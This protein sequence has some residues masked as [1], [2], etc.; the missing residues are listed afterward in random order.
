[1]PNG[2]PDFHEVAEPDYERFFVPIATPLHD[3][4][5]RHNVKLEKYYHEAPVW[6]FLFRHPLGGVA[7]NDVEKE[8]QAH[9]TLWKYW[10][11]DDYDSG[12]RSI[13]QSRSE[14]FPCEPKDLAIRLDNALNEILSW[15]AQSW[16]GRHGGFSDI[17]QGAW[18]REAFK[19]MELAYPVVTP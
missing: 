12:V 5:R 15:P 6:S 13:R 10:W 2:T 1:M 8:S 14:K 16:T 9:C 11:S 7:K 18:S 3:F 19:Q 4:A 17:W